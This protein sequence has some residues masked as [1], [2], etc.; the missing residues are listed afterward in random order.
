M[1]IL[2]L[3]IGLLAIFSVSA[4]SAIAEEDY[5]VWVD[6]NG[7]TNYAQRNPQGYNADYVGRSRQFGQHIDP[8]RPGAAPID[9]EQS[10]NSSTKKQTKAIDP[11]ALVA[12]ERAALTAEINAT[13]AS[14]CE[15]GKKNL[16]QLQ[17]FNRIRVQDEDGVT[18]VLT[19]SE[20]DDKTTQARQVIQENCSG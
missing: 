13:K 11:D 7:V 9:V 3:N 10:N 4:M 16:A 15:I 14:N 5:Y 1:R 17:T 2:I 20:K 12:E 19:S 6:E 8:R 18:R